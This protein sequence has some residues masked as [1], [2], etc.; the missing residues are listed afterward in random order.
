[1]ECW[2]HW[3]ILKEQVLVSE[4][5]LEPKERGQIDKFSFKKMLKISLMCGA[6]VLGTLD[7]L[8]PLDYIWNKHLC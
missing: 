6:S 4:M 2:W 8:V 5:Q 1:M 7:S 3:Y